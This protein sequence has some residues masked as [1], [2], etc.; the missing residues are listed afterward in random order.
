MF[1]FF[2]GNIYFLFTILISLEDRHV[3]DNNFRFIVRFRFFRL[4]F[5]RLG[6]IGFR[7]VGGRGEGGG[8][9][10]SSVSTGFY[11]HGATKRRRCSRDDQGQ[12]WCKRSARKREE[13]EA[14]F[15]KRDKDRA[16]RCARQGLWDLAARTSACNRTRA[17][18]KFTSNGLLV[19]LIPFH[20]FH[21]L[22]FNLF[23]HFSIY[24][25]IIIIIILF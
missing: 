20:S 14:N 7:F 8:E 13:R 21:S 5:V 12:R 1:T 3:I 19:F 25:Y 22:F 16:R 10:E 24:F 17:F 4:G 2:N 15:Q 23:I 18:R 11:S 9:A 6:L